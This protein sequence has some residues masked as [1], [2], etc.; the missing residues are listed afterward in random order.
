MWDG[1]YTAAQAARGK[2]LFL[3]S[4]SRCH[5]PELV[6]SERGPALKGELFWSHWEDD[7]LLTLFTKIRDTMPQGGIESVPDEGKLDILAHILS[8][9][10]VPAG[11]EE[12]SLEPGVL[13]NIHRAPRRAARRRR[14]P[15]SRSCRR[16]AAWR[17]G[18]TRSGC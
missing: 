1:V 16:W 5:N 6:G 9:N 11:T 8:M 18:R 2:A 7:A 14:W 13:E 10:D 15:T 4:C 12:M 17:A 3:N